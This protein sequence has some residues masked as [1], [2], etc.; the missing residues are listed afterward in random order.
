MASAEW[1]HVPPA[2][3][4]RRLSVASS[5]T[6]LASGNRMLTTVH[7][8]RLDASRRARERQLNSQLLSQISQSPFA[9]SSTTGTLSALSSPTLVSHL[10]TSK[11]STAL[12]RTGALGLSGTPQTPRLDGA[13]PLSFGASAGASGLH[14]V[15]YPRRRESDGSTYLSYVVGEHKTRLSDVPGEYDDVDL[16]ELAAQAAR[17]QA[18]ATGQPLGDPPASAAP[19]PSPASQQ[20]TEEATASRLA[21]RLEPD[22]A[23]A[24]VGWKSAFAASTASSRTAQ[25]RM[26]SGSHP[27]S[28][29]LTDLSTARP[30]MQPVVK[31]TV[32]SDYTN[33]A[34]VDQVAKPSSPRRS[35]YQNVSTSLPPRTPSPT[36]SEEVRE[37]EIGGQWRKQFG[38]N[39]FTS[40]LEDDD[41]DPEQQ[42]ETRATQNRC[43]VVSGSDPR[44]APASKIQFLSL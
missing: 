15:Q 39:N 16:D 18:A 4:S 43:A 19:V 11:L 32:V 1:A 24:S 23:A 35:T 36:P 9:R 7:G 41:D 25:D 14:G 27:A 38:N 26:V 10:A 2:G 6:S 42:W 29:S 28:A 20:P 31:H 12:P 3:G 8:S 17:D 40:T 5:S 22:P 21:L 44:I 33:P 37:D 34:I 30:S 13:S